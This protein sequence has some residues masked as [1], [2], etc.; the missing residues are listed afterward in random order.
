MAVCNSTKNNTLRGSPDAGDVPPGGFGNTGVRAHTD[1]FWFNAISAYVG[2]DH[3][4]LGVN[5][6]CWLNAWAWKWDGVR[7]YVAEKNAYRVAPCA[8]SLNCP[9]QEIHFPES[10][11]GLITMNFTATVGSRVR[12]FYMDSLNLGWVNNTC[13][14]GLKRI[15]VKKRGFTS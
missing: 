9:L 11:T 14:A 7:E 8:E 4:G 2:C 3:A 12:N 15:S 1:L 10:W 13:E 5:D 6:A